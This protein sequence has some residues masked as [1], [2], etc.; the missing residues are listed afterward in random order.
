MP[1]RSPS[2]NSAST[3]ASYPIIFVGMTA[4]RRRHGVFAGPEPVRD[5]QGPCL[6]M[7]IMCRPLCAVTPSYLPL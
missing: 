7:T 5:A 3:A 4:P 6:G 1:C 2:L